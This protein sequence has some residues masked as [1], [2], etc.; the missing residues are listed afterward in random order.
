MIFGIDI[1]IRGWALVGL[2]QGGDYLADPMLH[3]FVTD[4][5]NRWMELRSLALRFTDHVVPGD[6]VFLEEPPL[7]GP[8]N[9]RT[10]LGL[11]QTCGAI[12]GASKADAYVV[13][14][15]SW[16]K[17]VIG[18]G[19]ASK[20]LVAAWLAEHRPQLHDYCN[21]NQNLMDAACIAL[22]GEETV[23]ASNERREA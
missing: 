6:T 10:F 1:G 4:R 12:L 18:N 9:I 22:Y 7:A 13:P 21:G 11:A 15:S 5:T 2:P 14:V 19:S 16:K 8:R 23:R 20:E 17:A 3:Y